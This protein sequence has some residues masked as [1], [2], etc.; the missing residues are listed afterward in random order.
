LAH[1]TDNML[2]KSLKVNGPRFRRFNDKVSTKNLANTVN[3][4]PRPQKHNALTENLP[5][6]LPLLNISSKSASKSMKI[7]NKRNS[8]LEK[9]FLING[10]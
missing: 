7:F 5:P 1:K 3:Y 6:P 9:S 8:M 2:E 10:A 4:V